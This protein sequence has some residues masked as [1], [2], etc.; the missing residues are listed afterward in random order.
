MVTAVMACAAVSPMPINELPIVHEER[1]IP[2]VPVTS[3][4][5]DHHFQDWKSSECIRTPI[6]HVC[7]DA[8]SALVVRD[9][10]NIAIPPA[11]RGDGFIFVVVGRNLEL[12]E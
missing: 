4:K 6:T 9:G 11:T 5:T 12:A 1:H 2:H 10:I 3:V 7:V 8:I